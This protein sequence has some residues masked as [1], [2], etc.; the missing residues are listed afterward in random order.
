M[1]AERR[2][3]VIEQSVPAPF[4][5]TMTYRVATDVR[6]LRAFVSA[7]AL[8]RG[9]PPHRV[10][11]LTLAVS[12]LASNTLQHT[13]GGGRVVLWAE[14]GHLFCDVVDRGPTRRFGQGL[15]ATDA[16]RGRG[17]AIVEQIC[18]EVTVLTG[19]GETV[20]RIRLAL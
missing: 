13:T 2:D 10:E 18:D 4:A 11:L 7:G 15:P 9:L 5:E 17:L 3:T 8:A 6:A 16:V 1:P 19:A 12:E 20:V 14:S